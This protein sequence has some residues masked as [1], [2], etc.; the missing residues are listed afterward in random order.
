MKNKVSVRT[1]ACRELEVEKRLKP[2]SF[3][4]R[5]ERWTNIAAGLKYRGQILISIMR[6][7]LEQGET[8]ERGSRPRA[9]YNDM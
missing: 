3:A 6:T 7:R 1:C 5:A 8:G 2:G 4:S 9:E